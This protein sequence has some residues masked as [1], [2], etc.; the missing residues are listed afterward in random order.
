MA[1]VPVPKPR[2]TFV[3]TMDGV[4]LVFPTRLRHFQFAFHTVW[5]AGW[6]L[7]G[8]MVGAQL[9]PRFT[10]PEGPDV[11]SAFLVVWLCA[12]LLGECNVILGLAWQ[13]VGRE[14]VV[15]DASRVLVRREIGI[16]GRSKAYELESVR[17]LRVSSDAARSRSSSLPWSQSGTIAFDYGAK[18]VRFGSDIDEAEARAIVGVLRERGVGGAAAS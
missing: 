6:T 17:D 16:L 2:S 14:R 4:E 10:G 9:L 12:W 1:T 15:I 8:V 13:L 5:L 18:T 11:S 3:E 7:G